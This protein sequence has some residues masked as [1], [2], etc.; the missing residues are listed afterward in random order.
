MMSEL[1]SPKYI[2]KLQYLDLSM[3]TIPTSALVELLSHCTRLKK[4]SLEHVPLNDAVCKELA[5]NRQL[6][7]LN[8]AMCSGISRYGVRKIL[9]SL[10]R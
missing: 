2:S 7:V 6:E 5:N 4:I 8:L 10:K 3:A 1:P 9:S